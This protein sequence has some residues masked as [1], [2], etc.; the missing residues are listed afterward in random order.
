MHVVLNI[1]R[2]IN[3]SNGDSY[4]QEQSAHLSKKVLEVR[5]QA[6]IWKDSLNDIVLKI[7][8]KLRCCSQAG[9]LERLLS[10]KP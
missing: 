5:L 8:F 4:E 3:S 1:M 2:T 10:P 7:Y 6:I 9:F